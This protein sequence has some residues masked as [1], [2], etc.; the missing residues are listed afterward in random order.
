MDEMENL[1][2]KAILESQIRGERSI[3]KVRFVL[4][5]ILTAF[6]LSIFL[7]C[8]AADGFATE[9]KRAHY[10]VELL[11]LLFATVISILILRITSQGRYSAWMRFVPSFIDVSC[12]AAVHWAISSSIGQALAF[13]GAT[14]WFYTLFLVLS[15]FRN[16][17]ASVIFTGAYSAVAFVS[18]NTAI[19]GAMGN[20]DPAKRVYTNVAGLIVKLDFDDEVIKTLVILVAAGLLAIVSRR[21]KQMVQDQIKAMIERE[22]SKAAITGRTK[23]VAA[24]IGARSSDLEEV[25]AG[26][27]EGV[28][29]LARAADRIKDEIQGEQALVEQVGTT[30][31]AMI[32]STESTSA[33]LAEQAAMIEKAVSSM[34]TIFQAVRSTMGVAKDGSAVATA[35]LEIAEA[36]ERTL[37]QASAGVARTEEAGSRI[38]EIAALISDVADQTNLLAMNAAI[39]ASHAG[40]AG[41]G[42]AVVASEIRK[43]AEGT[44]ANARQIDTVLK[45]VTEG[46]RTVAEGSASLGTA[47]QS[48]VRN[49]ESTAGI[50]KRILASM[51]EEAAAAD[52]V[53]ALIGRLTSITEGV[54]AAG[55]EQAVSASEIERAV[56]RLKEQS[57]LI[58]GLADDQ[59]ARSQQLRAQ[60]GRLSSVVES[61]AKIIAD[62]DETVSA[63]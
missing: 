7:E 2:E 63:F 48:V 6:A 40:A 3:A 59:A 51:E 54:K 22:K 55:A 27:T 9:I 44:Q 21:F 39:E 53:A 33:S 52:S 8:V 19:Y 36:G 15:V 60:L 56:G 38:S 4:I 32:A 62:L 35:M 45:T 17:A 37:V 47:L 1:A 25:A 41:K 23:S 31:A 24:E 57:V 58:N 34:E 50:S 29:E 14:V 26:S 5:A 18:I 43:L 11:C 46:I 10:Y 28:A 42:F 30:I 16:S 12:V 61:H 49:A 20:F 13:S